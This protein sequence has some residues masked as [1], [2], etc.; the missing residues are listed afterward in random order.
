MLLLIPKY[1]YFHAKFN[2]LFFMILLKCQFLEI[3]ALADLQDLQVRTKPFQSQIRSFANGFC[4][5]LGNPG[6]PGNPG[7]EGPQGPPGS[8]GPPGNDAQ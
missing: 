8:V 2:F 5:F 3:R 4:Y 7:K 6:Q 1:F